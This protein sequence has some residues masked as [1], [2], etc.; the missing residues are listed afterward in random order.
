MGTHRSAGGSRGVS[1]GLVVSV[2]AVLL[3]IAAVGGWFWLSHRADDESRSAAAEC[4]EGSAALAVTVDPDV[5]TPV[6]AAARRFNAT[7]P[8]VRDHCAS[9]RV[10]ARPSA[11]MVAGFT[12]GAWNP[13]LGAQP[14]LWIPDSSRSV[15]AMRVPGLVEGTPTPVAASPIVL[16]VPE[17]LRQALD[18]AK[19]RWADLPNLQQGSLGDIGL[20]GWGGLRLAL[21]GGD[22]ADGPVEDDGVAVAVTV[23]AALSSGDPLTDEA[24]RS[25]QVIAAI[26]KLA[27]GAPRP[28]DTAAGLTELAAPGDPA[29]AKIHAVPVTEQQLKAKGGLAEFRPAGAEPIADYPAALLNGPWVDKTQNLIA[30]LFV[31]YLRAPEQQKLFAD[32]GFA[33]APATAP[34]VPAKSVVEQVRSV[35]ANPVLGVQA[36]VLLDTSAAMAVTDGTLTRL[37]NALGALRSTVDTMPPD[38]GLGVWTYDDGADDDKPYQIVSPTAGLDQQHR[39]DVAKALSS[40]TPGT[41]KTDRAYPALQAAYRG[42]VAGFSPGRTN[43]VVLITGGPNDT[44]DIT[45]DE[46]IA[47]IT[48]ATDPARPVRIDVIALGSQPSTTL[49]TLA[50]KT[51]GSYTRLSTTNDLA[52]GTAVSKVLTTP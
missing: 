6:E 20:K 40:L 26:S 8:K 27:A 4:V 11:A 21:P 49:Q 46:L 2:V 15:E 39:K 24:A 33:A 32:N 45:G 51:G 34:A 44:S 25:G 17:P 22:G 30:G 9:V 13:Q 29:Q 41:A 47:D 10:I 16:G 42:A 5:L 37:G 50:E 1:K 12:G 43:S 19:T 14:A 38:F 35:L 28:A 7:N 18:N 3:V 52:F 36:T 48:A 31:D 23:G